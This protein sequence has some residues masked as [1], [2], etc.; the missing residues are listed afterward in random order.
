VSVSRQSE[1]RQRGGSFKCEPAKLSMLIADHGRLTPFPDCDDIHV[2]GDGIGNLKVG[3]GD[4]AERYV[5]DRDDT[6]LFTAFSGES[7]IKRF[8]FLNVSSREAPEVG[9]NSAVRAAAN[10]RNGVIPHKQS[11]D[12][13]VRGVFLARKPSNYLRDWCR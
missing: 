3:I 5:S 4:G 1:A 10:Q 13:I 11:V 9:I 8:I 2:I 7:L 6:D 12:D